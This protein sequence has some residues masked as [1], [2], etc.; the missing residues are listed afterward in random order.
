MFPKQNMEIL[1]KPLELGLAHRKVWL[2]V[3]DILQNTEEIH[4]YSVLKAG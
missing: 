4:T 1:N 3:E 2:G